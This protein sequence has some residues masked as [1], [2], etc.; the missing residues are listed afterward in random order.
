M[1]YYR[2]KLKPLTDEVLRNHY[3]ETNRNIIR[4]IID[5]DIVLHSVESP[6]SVKGRGSAYRFSIPSA[7][8]QE[9][10][11][12]LT[13]LIDSRIRIY[14]DHFIFVGTQLGEGQTWSSTR[15]NLVNFDTSHLVDQ[16][17]TRYAF[18]DRPVNGLMNIVIDNFAPKLM[19]TTRFD[20]RHLH[21]ISNFPKTIY[22]VSPWFAQ[23][24]GA[25]QIAPEQLCRVLGYSVKDLKLLITKVKRKNLSIGFVGYGGTNVNTIHWLS[26]IMKFTHTVNLFNFIE[27]FEPDTLEVSNLLRFPKNPHIPQNNEHIHSNYGVSPSSKLQLLDPVELS[28][29]S[30]N[31]PFIS[32]LRVNGNRAGSTS[33]Q[34]VIIY[35][36]EAGQYVSKDS[37]VYYGAPTIDTRVEFEESGHFISATH[38]GNSAH[39]WL[40]PTQDSDLQVES[41]GLI[42]LTQF[43]MNQLRLAIGLLEVLAADDVDYKEK[44]KLL[45]E[46]SFDGVA[47]LPTD[48]LY[49]F[50]LEGHSGLVTTETEA[51]NAW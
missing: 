40:N 48:R 37:H 42:S 5:N 45:L 38:K 14:H 35:N 18:F 16:I 26:E 13:S 43:F 29:L 19:Y 2:Y 30:K 41:Y 8:I 27:V 34:K 36:R 10:N 23:Y 12:T 47:K 49:N 44:D 50:Q 3:G 25:K 6:T 21:R 32:P 46:Y 20:P 39:L 11:P 4:T 9:L 24:F 28:L 7:R 31:K 22:A 15:T 51:D 17:R 33:S 1:A